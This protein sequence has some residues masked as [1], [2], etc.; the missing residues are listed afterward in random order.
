MDDT[1][2]EIDAR[3]LSNALAIAFIALKGMA[4]S[5]TPKTTPFIMNALQDFD[6]AIKVLEAVHSNKLPVGAKESITAIRAEW[7]DA[8][9]I[10]TGKQRTN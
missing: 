6:K 4:H 7:E 1:K 9:K 2:V 10:L 8:A 5:N 3:L